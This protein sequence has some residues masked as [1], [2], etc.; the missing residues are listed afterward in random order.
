MGKTVRKGQYRI[1]FFMLI[2]CR[3][4]LYR[5]GMRSKPSCHRVPWI[6][7]IPLVIFHGLF[8]HPVYHWPTWRRR[9]SMEHCLSRRSIQPPGKRDHRLSGCNL[10]VTDLLTSYVRRIVDKL[11]RRGLQ[12]RPF[13]HKIIDPSSHPA[14]FFVGQARYPLVADAIPHRCQFDFLYDILLRAYLSLFPTD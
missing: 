12:H 10:V 5:L 14:D 1:R 6:A 3:H 4:L 7:K 13:L 11:W 2:I 9:S 8:G